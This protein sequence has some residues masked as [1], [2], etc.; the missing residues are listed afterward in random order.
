MH[1]NQR[2]CQTV[3]VR[4]ARGNSV[5]IFGRGGFSKA[6]PPLWAVVSLEVLDNVGIR[7]GG[8]H[9]PSPLPEDGMKIA[10][11]TPPPSHTYRTHYIIAEHV[12]GPC[13][14]REPPL[15]TSFSAFSNPR[16][17]KSPMVQHHL[18]PT[19]GWASIIS[20]SNQKTPNRSKT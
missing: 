8:I 19:F 2:N 1:P 5:L 20:T 3:E 16:P 12:P 14:K 4:E 9:R 15:I 13:K 18:K 7:E 6:P 10:C 11:V 17:T